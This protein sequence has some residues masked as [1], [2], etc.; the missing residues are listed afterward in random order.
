M[1]SEMHP[2]TLCQRGLPEF[3]LGTLRKSEA[4]PKPSRT[5]WS[6]P[7]QVHAEQRLKCTLPQETLTPISPCQSQ[8][9]WTSTA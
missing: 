9:P 5:S 7:A 2:S 6:L 4:G 8:D 3:S 1:G